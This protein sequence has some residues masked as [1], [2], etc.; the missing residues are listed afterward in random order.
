MN[1]HLILIPIGLTLSLGGLALAQSVPDGIDLDKIRERAAEHSEEAQALATNVR[2]RAEAL[3]E[4]AQGVQVQAQANR[5]SYADSIEVTETD[6]VLDFDAMIAGQAQ[7]EKA[8]LGESPRFIAF[9]SLSMPPAAL[10]ALVHDMTRAGGVT[11]LRGFPEGNSAAFKKRLAAIWSDSNEAGSLG[12]DPRLFRAFE[13]KAA[14]SFV[15]LSTDFAPCDGFDCTSNVPPHDR[16]AG[17]I[18]VGEVLETFASGQGPGADLA[19][20]HRNR[21][22]GDQ[23]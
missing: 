19:R 20:L 6:A 5:A 12:I 9:A 3:T 16:I 1:K 10:K 8:S 2:E 22:Q 7:A 14:P 17:N 15:M 23:R 4:D 11:V 18:S 13:I 21:L